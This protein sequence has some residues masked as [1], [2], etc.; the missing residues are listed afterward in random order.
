MTPFPRIDLL[1]ALT[2]KDLERRRAALG[3]TMREYGVKLDDLGKSQVEN[4][5]RIGRVA[6][7]V[8]Q[9]DG[10]RKLVFA[11]LDQVKVD[12]ASSTS[13]QE[14]KSSQKDKNEL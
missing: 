12:D 4:V 3:L 13:E 7:E 8:V 14:A 6:F 1:L 10:R 2:P 11:D 5:L 9:G